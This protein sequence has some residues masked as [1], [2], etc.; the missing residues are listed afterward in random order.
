MPQKKKLLLCYW[1]SFF[2]LASIII[3]YL[4]GWG[5]ALDG[6]EIPIV[7][8][9]IICLSVLAGLIISL[10]NL[11]LAGFVSLVISLIVGLYFY[12]NA[13]LLLG[14]FTGITLALVFANE[15]LR[16]NL[17]SSSVAF[18]VVF[19][20]GALWRSP[21]FID[22]IDTEATVLAARADLK[23]VLHIVLDEQGSFEYL[24]SQL[25]DPTVPALRAHYENE[26]FSVIG[27][28]KS[29]SPDTL[30][31]FS[32]FLNTTD[33]AVSLG[34]GR[35][36]YQFEGSDYFDVL[37][38]LGY[39]VSVLSSD[40]LN[41][42][43]WDSVS[44][45]HVYGRAHHFEAAQERAPLLERMRL[46]GLAIKQGLAG[47]ARYLKEISP[48]IARFLAEKEFF[49][50][51]SI[52]A[53]GLF[54]HIYE[55][56]SRMQRGDYYFAHVILPH[57]PYVWGEGCELKQVEDMAGPARYN[58]HR[59]PEL[60]ANSYTK[61]WE[62]MQCVHKS[63]SALLRKLGATSGLDELVVVVHGDHGPRIMGKYGYRPDDGA[64]ED[65]LR[66]SLEVLYMQRGLGVPELSAEKKLRP[67]LQNVLS[68][69]SKQ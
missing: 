30:H 11:L 39:K 41:L 26:G 35:F 51:R 38:S 29:S 56:S 18:C 61:Y 23:P 12:K 13:I 59:T 9:S 32:N 4:R 24:D 15:E 66:D 1:F 37:K 43:A 3:P 49:Y 62:Q 16:N 40:H 63:I 57:F 44:S 2:G 7:L 65:Q 22:R 68:Q 28:V 17:V 33:V 64:T 46:L 20:F 6:A 34:D 60:F 36:S 67:L 25:D 5:I 10:H 14:V 31:S 50:T 69:L 8:F 55:E 45:C 54:E 53:L 27:G 48:G 42:C 21:E 52:S 47:G 58:K 19:L